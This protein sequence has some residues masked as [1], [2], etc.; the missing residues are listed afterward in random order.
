MAKELMLLNR[1]VGGDWRESLDCKEIKPVNPKGN[2]SWIFIGRTD[3]ESEAPILWPPNA[4]NW[5]TGKTLLL[6]KTKGRRRKEWQRMKWLGGI[7]DWMDMRLS[8][9]WE[10]VKDR[11]VQ[12]A[13][14]H[15]VSK[16]WTPLKRL[17]NKDKNDNGTGEIR[18]G[19]LAHHSLI[20]SKW[21]NQAW[22]ACK[23]PNIDSTCENHEV[24]IRIWNQS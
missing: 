15:R 18:N 21:L 8:K 7:I 10:I 6:G 24:C 16:T 17:N 23:A 12:C 4:K 19:W 11:E 5:L 9:L 13:S 20:D 14:V 1:G 3:A 22:G 2:Q